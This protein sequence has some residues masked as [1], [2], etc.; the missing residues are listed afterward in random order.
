MTFQNVIILSKSQ[1]LIR[2]RITI[3]YHN[4]FLKKDSYKESDT[5]YFSKNL[6]IL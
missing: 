5:P 2:I 1:L 4:T 6:C 3:Y